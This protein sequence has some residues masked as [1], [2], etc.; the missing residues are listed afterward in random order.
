MVSAQV[1]GKA[2]TAVALVSVSDSDVCETEARTACVVGADAA[3]ELD[4]GGGEAQ[5]TIPMSRR[6][7]LMIRL[8]S[9][10]PD[11]LRSG[12]IGRCT[13]RVPFCEALHFL[14]RMKRLNWQ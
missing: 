1:S 6:I 11:C 12:W 4:C 3:N 8:T 13:M 14:Y 5:A 9:A 10:K 2:G 7:G